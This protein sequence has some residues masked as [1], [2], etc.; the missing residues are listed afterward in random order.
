LI[1]IPAVANS[2]SLAIV[3]RMTVR[4]GHLLLALLFLA[5]TSAR[6][7]EPLAQV[8]E[9]KITILSTMLAD[10][11]ELGEWGFAAIVDVD[12][13]RILFDTG[14][15]EDLVLKN[16]ITLGVD[17]RDVPEVVLSHNHWD[18]VGGLLT[19]RRSVLT[20]T[21]GAL[22]RV[23]VG[24]GIFN[25]RGPSDRGGDD[26][27]IIQIR[28]EYEAT[29][30]EFIVHDRPVQ[31]HPGVWLTG[32]VSRKY[33][34]RNWSGTGTVVT[35]AGTVEDNIPEDVALVFNTAEGLV[36]LTG[37][38]HAGV[39]NIIQHTRDVI[40]PARVHALVGGLHLFNASE[41]SLAWTAE[42]LREFGV[43]H[44]IGAHCTGIEP[45][46][47]FRSEVGLDRAH[48]VVGAVGATFELGK[49][50]DP[51]WLAR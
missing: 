35:P 31:L 5:G 43:D 2:G 29:G 28:P 30:G 34:E 19:L 21:P 22:A 41:E 20:G 11:R 50:I 8:R 47:R 33:P 12:G 38:G 48:A 17:L 7:D 26:K 23:H 4:V 16:A 25:S 32:P 24:E 40:R 14:A 1:R 3:Y 45:V 49:G 42:K 46:Y 36:I 44:F 13:H 27:E 15:R 10:G 51:R 9:L 6:A 39:I 37:C 18:H